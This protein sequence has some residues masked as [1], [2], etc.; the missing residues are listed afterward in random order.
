MTNQVTKEKKI[1]I[2]KTKTK[3]RFKKVIIN[4]FIVDKENIY[5]AKK[6]QFFLR[7]NKN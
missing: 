2:T 1:V 7:E 3:G 4:R 6:D 5:K